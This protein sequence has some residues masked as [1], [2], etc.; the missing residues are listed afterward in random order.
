MGI[1][2]ALPNNQLLICMLLDIVTEVFIGYPN[3]LIGIYRINNFD[4]IG[5]STA[6]VCLRF[7]LS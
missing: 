2:V 3:N 4:S 6:N 5:G 7:N 1:A